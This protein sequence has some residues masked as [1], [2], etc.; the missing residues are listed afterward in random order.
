MGQLEQCAERRTDSGR[1]APV[2]AHLGSS[3][4]LSTEKEEYLVG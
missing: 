2:P 4:F 1:G 3:G